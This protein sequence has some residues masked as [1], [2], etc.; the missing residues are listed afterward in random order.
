MDKNSH[1]P[2]ED[3][4]D[5]VK[6]SSFEEV[7]RAFDKLLKYHMKMLLRD[8]NAKVIRQEIFKLPMGNYSL[9]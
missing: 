1:H 6:D 7:E 4:R 5:D 8:L 2:S 3:E 9:Y